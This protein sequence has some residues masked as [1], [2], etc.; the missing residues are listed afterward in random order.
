M[1]PRLSLLRGDDSGSTGW[2]GT[3]GNQI[4]Q[5]WSNVKRIVSG[6]DGII[7]AV[8]DDGALPFFQDLNRNGSPGWSPT[9]GSQIGQGWP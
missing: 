2:S 6:G 5:G 7:Y 3:S 8:R 1:G 4:G 9:S